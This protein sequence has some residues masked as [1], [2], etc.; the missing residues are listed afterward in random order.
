MW[1]HAYF[2][3][4]CLQLVTSQ[5]TEVYRYDGISATVYRRREYFDSAHPYC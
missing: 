1:F 2:W 5:N 3:R 4:S